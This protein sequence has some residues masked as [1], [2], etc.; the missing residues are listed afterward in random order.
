MWANFFLVQ[1]TFVLTFCWRK[2]I[3]GFPLG[4]LYCRRKFTHLGLIMNCLC[5][6]TK[7]FNKIT[8]QISLK[9]LLLNDLFDD[10]RLNFIPEWATVSLQTFSIIPYPGG[11]PTGWSCPPPLP[12]AASWAPMIIL[13][14]VLCVPITSVSTAEFWVIV[15]NRVILY[16]MPQLPVSCPVTL[17]LNRCIAN[18]R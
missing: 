15:E 5:C 2:I 18:N 12:S 11:W 10:Q 3:I 13:P 9:N 4:W 7:L 17:I 8:F 16:T 6:S 14:N 1:I